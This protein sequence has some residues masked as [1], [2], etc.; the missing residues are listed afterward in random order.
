MSSATL[1]TRLGSLLREHRLAA[2]LTQRQLGERAGGISAGEVW[3]FESGK[4]APTLETL[5]RIAQGLHV[6][7]RSLLDIETDQVLP[8]TPEVLDEEEAETEEPDELTDTLERLRVQPP[9]L[10]STIV[11]AVD[12]LLQ[13]G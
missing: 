5:S 2:Q 13:A 7:L 12:A 11:A 4:R 6:P 8:A 9:E 10:I 1:R 3:R